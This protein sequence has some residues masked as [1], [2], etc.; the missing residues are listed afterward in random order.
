M[1]VPTLAPERTVE[2]IVA[3]W[4]LGLDPDGFDN[5]AGPLY[6]SGYAESEITRTGGTSADPLTMGSWCTPGQCTHCC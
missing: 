5:P 1:G 6:F 3:G 2:E 4:R